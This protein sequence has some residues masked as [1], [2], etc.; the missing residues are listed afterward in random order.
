MTV[1]E[2]MTVLIS[3]LEHY[4]YCPRQC[5]LIHVE[6]IFTENVFTLQGRAIHEHADESLTTWEGTTR[7]ERALPL[8]SD[9]LGLL[10]KADV[11]EFHAD[12]RVVPIEYKRGRKRARRAVDVQLCAQA[13]CLE[14]ML[15]V[16][17]PAGQVFHH[18]SHQSRAVAFT[19]DVRAETE[20]VI[21]D[22]RALL[23]AGCLPP[24]L[25]ADARCPDCSLVEACQPALLGECRGADPHALFI[26]AE[27]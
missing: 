9:R 20:V 25:A 16:A 15:G 12:G 1:A 17:V 4:V 18:A 2:E 21:A 5:A 11:V 22:V 13:L 7:I 14:E 23:A 27:E 19:A 8:W 10:G 6:G 3:A 26:I 24:P